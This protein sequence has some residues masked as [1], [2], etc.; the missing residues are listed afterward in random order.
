MPAK[1]TA[2]KT[3]AKAKTAKAKTTTESKA[4]EPTTTCMLTPRR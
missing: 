3:T 2:K 4:K 1:K